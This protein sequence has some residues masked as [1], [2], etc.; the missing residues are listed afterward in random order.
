M[1]ETAHVTAEGLEEFDKNGKKKEKRR[2]DPRDFRPGYYGPDYE[3]RKAAIHREINSNVLK[4]DNKQLS[5]ERFAKTKEEKEKAKIVKAKHEA[6]LRAYGVDPKKQMN[7]L[8]DD[9]EKFEGFRPEDKKKYEREANKRKHY[10]KQKST[11]K[12]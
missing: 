7:L 1:A 9:L 2:D 3:R 4:N 5:F 10:R 11:K 12:K 8:P 6:L